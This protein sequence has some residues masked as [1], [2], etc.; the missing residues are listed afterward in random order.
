MPPKSNSIDRSADQPTK[1]DIQNLDIP[2]THN[3]NARL[4]CPVGIRIPFFSLLC[5]NDNDC[6]A[7]GERMV[8]CKNRCIEGI[9]PQNNEHGKN[10]NY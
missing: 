2:G 5:T 3:K 9:L 4:T 6:S 10:I 8:C 7:S 1:V